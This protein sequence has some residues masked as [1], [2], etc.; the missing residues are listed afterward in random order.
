MVEHYGVGQSEGRCELIGSQYC[1]ESCK[2]S[3]LELPVFQERAYHGV[4][5]WVEVLC[6]YFVEFD[7]AI[8]VALAADQQGLDEIPLVAIQVAKNR[9]P[10]LV[11]DLVQQGVNRRAKDD[12]VVLSQ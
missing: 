12:G 11:V 3:L 10:N 2:N 6:L 9:V 5:V 4:P 8:A 7:R 1:D